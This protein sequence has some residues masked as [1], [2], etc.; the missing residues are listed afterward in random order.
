VK[1]RNA[2][3]LCM[4]RTIHIDRINKAERESLPESLLL[5][6]ASIFK[7]LGDPTRLRIVTALQGGEMCV[8]DLSAYLSLTESAVSHQLR[9]LRELN[10]IKNRREGQILFYSLENNLAADFLKTGLDHVREST[11]P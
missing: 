4:V 3:D 8:C 1:N 5:R 6:L 10:L 2:N 11:T 7:V 9:R